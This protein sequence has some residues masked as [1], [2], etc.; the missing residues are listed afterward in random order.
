MKRKRRALGAA[1]RHTIWAAA[2]VTGALLLAASAEAVPSPDA[3]QTKV[4]DAALRLRIRDALADDP[5]LGK[6]N[7]GVRIRDGVVTLHGPVPSFDVALHAIA[8]VKKQP[9]VSEV[10]NELYSPAV[11]E[12]LARA[13]P[14]PVTAARLTLPPNPAPPVADGVNGQEV[15]VAPTV[16]ARAVSLSLIEQIDRLR[17]RE[18]RFA[19]IRVEINEGRV[20]LRGFVP[21][22]RDA[23][24]FA[25]QVS[26]LPGVTGVVQGIR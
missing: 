18:R 24:D 11:D 5:V 10:R 13:L 12:P 22:A 8:L 6:F 1:N 23:W 9:G 25:D 2:L 15:A 14:K 20:Y 17:Q 21:R 3:P 26:R 16:T 4:G 19:D 7:L